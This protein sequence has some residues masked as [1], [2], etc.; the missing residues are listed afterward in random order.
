VRPPLLRPMSCARGFARSIGSDATMQVGRRGRATQRKKYRALRAGQRPEP[1]GRFCMVARICVGTKSC[2]VRKIR[3][4][5]KTCALTRSDVGSHLGSGGSRLGLVS[6][7]GSGGSRRVAAAT[8]GGSGPKR[9]R[10]YVVSRNNSG[11]PQRNRHRRS[12]H[13]SHARAKRAR[14]G[15]WREKRTR[16]RV[17][18]KN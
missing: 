6:H 14:P 12:P 13:R 11:K 1:H 18:V 15:N 8:S 7:L 16:T 2:T 3:A 10:E 17:L 4:R 9:R 5:T